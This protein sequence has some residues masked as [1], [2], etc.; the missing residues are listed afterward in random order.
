MTDADP[1]MTTLLLEGQIRGEMGECGDG[2][3]GGTWKG[4]GGGRGGMGNVR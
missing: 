2:R 1:I 4:R 3:R